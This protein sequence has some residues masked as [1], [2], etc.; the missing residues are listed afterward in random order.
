MA[1]NLSA[2]NKTP[3]RLRAEDPWMRVPSEVAAVLRE[4]VPQASERVLSAIRAEIPDYAHPLTGEFGRVAR[5]GVEVALHRFVELVERP[6]QDALGPSRAIYYDL[7]RGECRQGR[8]LDALLGAYRVGALV[9]WNEIVPACEAA[10][11]EPSTLYELAA[12]VFAYIHELSAVSAE[13]YS[14]ERGATQAARQELVELLTI[15]PTP[16]AHAVQAAADRAGCSLPAR[17]AVLVSRVGE[18][19]RVAAGIGPRAIGARIAGLAC[20]LVPDPQGPDRQRQVA[21]ALRGADAALGP[22]VPAS[23]APQ[24]WQWARRVLELME[25]GVIRERG[26]IS[27]EAHLATILIHENEDLAS[28]LVT[29]SLAPLQGQ[30]ERYRRELP[31]TLLAWLT[32]HG[33]VSSAAVDLH[34]H[35]QTV[36]Y[37]L[38]KLRELYGSALDDVDTRFELELALRAAG[39]DGRVG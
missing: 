5:N 11:V 27:V 15:R 24:T 28:A 1:G 34:V 4:A 23:E 12:A 2:Y 9:A 14:A 25:S 26:M 33:D 17:I 30:S 13:G 38:H 19:D 21:E 36:R 32:H 22:T 31:E 8:S 10:A 18:P 35:P 39:T 6:E 20:V 7:G 37:R 29:R 3:S 16:D